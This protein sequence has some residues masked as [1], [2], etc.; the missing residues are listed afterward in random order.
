M[1]PSFEQ[2]LAFVTV[3]NQGSFR[4][5]ARKLHKT[6]PT[7][8]AAIQNLELEIGFTLFERTHGK[9]TLTDKARGFMR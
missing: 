1:H 6:Q 3:V 5:A 4:A 8:S 2:L 7:I 9:A